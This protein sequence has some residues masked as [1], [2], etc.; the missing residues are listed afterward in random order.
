MASADRGHS[1]LVQEPMSRQVDIICWSFLGS[2][3]RDSGPFLK[4]FIS[5]RQTM[6][7]GGQRLKLQIST[8]LLFLCHTLRNASTRV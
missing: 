3:N 2:E 1:T 7:D 8:L 5:K 6:G 4:G